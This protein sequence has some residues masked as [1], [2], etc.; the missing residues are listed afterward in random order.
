MKREKAKERGGGTGR[1]RAKGSKENNRR[2]GRSERSRGE[3]KGG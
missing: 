2:E 1:R 3:S